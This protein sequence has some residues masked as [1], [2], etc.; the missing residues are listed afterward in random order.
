MFEGMKRKSEA[1]MVDLFCRM[2]GLRKAGTLDWGEVED[3][4]VDLC[5]N[6]LRGMEQRKTRVWTDEAVESMRRSV[7]QRCK[8]S[9]QTDDPIQVLGPVKHRYRGVKPEVTTADMF[10]VIGQHLSV[11]TLSRGLDRNTTG[12]I[13]GGVVAGQMALDAA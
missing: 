13:L 6:L 4:S 9:W 7:E 11:L 3:A 10:A 5:D 1:M 8:M 2:H 12:E